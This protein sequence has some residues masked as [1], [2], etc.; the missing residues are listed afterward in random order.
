MTQTWTKEAK[1]YQESG[2]LRHQLEHEIEHTCCPIYTDKFGRAIAKRVIA[3]REE[4]YSGLSITAARG[5]LTD[6]VLSS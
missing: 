2:E 6:D 4:A 3:P 1:D 5:D